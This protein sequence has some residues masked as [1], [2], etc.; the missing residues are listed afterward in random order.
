MGRFRIR[1]RGKDRPDTMSAEFESEDAAHAF[2]R[3]SND[4]S[5]TDAELWE[6]GKRR[7]CL[8][9]QGKS[10]ASFWI[11]DQE[12]RDDRSIDG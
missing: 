3:I 9:R 7:A 8:H 10:K 1:K 4:Q 6:D 2:A 5:C 12:G 11:I